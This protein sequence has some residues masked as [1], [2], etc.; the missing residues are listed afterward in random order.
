M[1]APPQHLAEAPG[2]C[3]SPRT[4]APPDLN[5]ACRK[6]SSILEPAAL[7]C[8]G[9]HTLVHAARL[10][11]LAAGARLHEER[12]EISDAREDWLQALELLPADSAQAEWVRGNTQRLNVMASTPATVDARHTWARKLGPFAPLAI[13]LVKG[14]FLLSL[15]K[16]KFLFSFGSFVAFYW[17]LYGVKFGVGFAAL[18]LLHE[19]GHFAE[20]KRR[21]LPAD[22]PVFLPGFG[23]YVRWTALGVST[24]TRAFVS[25]AGPMAGCIGAAI[26]AFLWVKTGAAFWIGLASLTALLNV[27]NLIPIWVL[28]GGQAIAALNKS[29]RIILSASA[30]LLAAWFEQ[31]FFLLV[32]AG[33]GYRVFDKNMPAT[34]SNPATAYYVALLAALGY[35]MHLAPLVPPAR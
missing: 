35:I 34:A 18:I 19:M 30:V 6:C 4:A 10:E 12:H 17:V 22:M 23:A 1:N 29:E 24:Q 15:F 3:D 5:Q 8:A 16:L 21:G 32:A 26:C 11:Q 25:L 20:I 2:N 33:A 27:L 9:C 14:K 28:D 31:P 7:V 13:L